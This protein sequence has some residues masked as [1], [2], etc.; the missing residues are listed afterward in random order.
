MNKFATADAIFAQ[1]SSIGAALRKIF[2]NLNENHQ[3]FILGA[4]F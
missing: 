4:F 3:Y 2:K 1:I